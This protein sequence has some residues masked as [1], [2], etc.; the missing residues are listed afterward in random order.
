[1][2]AKRLALFAA[3]M[4]LAQSAIADTA[5]TPAPAHEQGL[6][7]GRPVTYVL[8]GGRKI[9]EGDILLDHVTPLPSRT[10]GPHALSVG[11]AYPQYLWPKAES[12]VAA[13]PYVVTSSATQLSAALAAFNA[14]FKGAI[15]FVKRTT[16][17]DYVDF[18]FDTN[19]LSGQCESNVG[20]VGGEQFTGGSAS[21]DLGTL[22]HEMGH[23]AGLYHEQS[24]P[25]RSTFVTV[26][27]NN[28]IKGIGG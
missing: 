19:N 18:D 16:Q 17:T 12:G 7:R 5:P 8:D 2:S 23:I 9:F 21:C 26:N 27:F 6:F 24:R 14:T 15:Q 20:H 3:T 1:M 11:I 13:I 25:D 28:V 4:S 22:L 10:T